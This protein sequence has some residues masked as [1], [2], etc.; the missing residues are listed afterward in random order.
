MRSC[1]SFSCPRHLRMKLNKEKLH[2]AGYIGKWLSLLLRFGLC[3]HVWLVFFCTVFILWSR[4]DVTTQNVAQIWNKRKNIC[5]YWH[6]G[7]IKELTC[8]LA[9]IEASL[10]KIWSHWIKYCFG[11]MYC[12]RCSD[13]FTSENFEFNHFLFLGIFVWFL[14]TSPWSYW[15]CLVGIMNKNLIM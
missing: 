15:L 13:Q 11:S 3:V 12:W 9:N 8:Q 4:Y 7:H 14:W 1:V 2:G 6:L 10:I 5:L